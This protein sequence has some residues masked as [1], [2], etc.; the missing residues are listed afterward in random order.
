MTKKRGT[1]QTFTVLGTILI[2][3]ALPHYHIPTRLKVRSSS[4]RHALPCFY[5]ETIL[6]NTN[7]HF[8]VVYTIIVEQFSTAVIATMKEALLKFLPLVQAVFYSAFIFLTYVSPETLWG[9]HE[10]EFPMDP[11]WSYAV[12]AKGAAIT[13]LLVGS[14]LATY[15][16]PLPYRF[17]P[18]VSCG[19][20]QLLALAHH[21][22]CFLTEPE[23][24]FVDS[25]M[26]FQYVVV[27]SFG[28]SCF[29][30]LAYE[31][32]LAQEK[33]MVVATTKKKE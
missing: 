31:S 5:A 17:V 9:V 10:R 29:A 13:G 32:K 16:Q 23:G 26:H 21:G 24:Y 6:Y 12:K 14:L 1:S 2:T 20:F 4:F 27:H 30:F 18:Y 3:I 33:T 25:G 22:R 8:I 15:T 28:C 19:V 11:V 7:Q